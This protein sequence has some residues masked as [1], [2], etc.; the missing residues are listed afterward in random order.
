MI[1]QL[2]E[3]RRV[4]PP[5]YWTVW[6]ATLINR[7]G[8]FVVPLLTFY[9]IGERGLSIAE[10]G[11]IVSLFGAGGVAAALVGGMLA[12]HIGRRATMAISLLGGAVLM[13]ALGAADEPALI[14]VLTLALG[15]VGEIYRPAVSAF[16]ADVVPAEH[17]LRAYGL[18]H[19][20]INIGFSIAPL[21]AGFVA[22]WSYAALFIID[23]ATMAVF[24]VI[25]IL[26]L[27][28]TRPAR[29]TADGAPRI[30]TLRAL[31]DRTFR[32]FLFFTFLVALLF[33]QSSA[34]LSAWMDMQGHSTA[35]FG[36]VLAV[37]GI[38][39]V[40]TQPIITERLRTSDPRRVLVV[41]ALLAGTGFALHGVSALVAVHVAAVVTWTFA[42]IASTP[43]SAALVAGLAAPE[44]RGRY[45]GLF[46]M[47][48]GLASFVGP[49][50]GPRILE[51]AGPGPLWGGC[52][53]VG[54]IAA[55]GFASLGLHR[56]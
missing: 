20:A 34:S 54:A 10:A 9:L 45:Q 28:E 17:R 36:A 26:R 4:L 37:N 41:S 11:A 40:L 39:I 19:W 51:D 50:F 6:F 30:G 47:S 44:A 12:D 35:T 55:A 25:A 21:A 1:R 38:L 15:F 29:V 13:F 7:A 32:R 8:G 5:A 31:A 56:S 24:G 18:L 48:W 46:T 2:A 27:P 43:T 14:G 52:L 33:W 23:G 16:I 42:E 3:L 22:G 49:F 53:A